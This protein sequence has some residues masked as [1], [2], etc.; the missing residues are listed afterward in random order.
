MENGLIQDDVCNRDG[1]TGL[2]QEQD[3]DACCSCHI[4]PP[5]SHCTD[6]IFECDDCGA[7]TD[8]AEPAKSSFTPRPVKYKTTAERFTELADNEFNYVTIPGAYYWME[9]K[10]K[11]PSEMPASDILSKFNTCFGY[12]WKKMPSNGTFHLKVYTD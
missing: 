11:Y 2:M 3:N 4:C 9:Y 12:M 6:M 8:L 5:C 10:G 7:E 1:C